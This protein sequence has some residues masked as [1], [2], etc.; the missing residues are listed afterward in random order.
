[1]KGK[2]SQFLPSLLLLSNELWSNDGFLC[3]VSIVIAKEV[4]RLSQD[5]SEFEKNFK[6]SHIFL[7][8]MSIVW[9]FVHYYR[10]IF[11]FLLN[12]FICVNFVN[13]CSLNFTFFFFF[14]HFSVSVARFLSFLYVDR[15]ISD[16]FDETR[17]KIK[18]NAMHWLDD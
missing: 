2:Q 17:E 10:N 9:I 5:V 12:F 11:N 8:F 16:D 15:F 18:W 14:L 3:A 1:M 13:F 4:W 7:F 6:K